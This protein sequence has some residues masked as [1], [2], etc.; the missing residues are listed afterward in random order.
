MT[1]L[2]TRARQ[3]SDGVINEPGDVCFQQESVL[4]KD[5]RRTEGNHSPN[6]ISDWQSLNHSWAGTWEPA[7]SQSKHNNTVSGSGRL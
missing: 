1:T 7:F 3:G 6:L 5:L 2:R 4:L